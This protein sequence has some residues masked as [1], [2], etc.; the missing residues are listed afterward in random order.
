RN[1]LSMSASSGTGPRRLSPMHQRKARGVGSPRSAAVR[2]PTS[3][4]QPAPIEL[5]R[6]QFISGAGCITKPCERAGQLPTGELTAGRGRQEAIG[7]ARGGRVAGEEDFG[8]VLRE[9]REL[10]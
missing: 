2:H 1:E 7:V 6:P 5:Q 3:Q 9:G 10:V 8:D 4:E